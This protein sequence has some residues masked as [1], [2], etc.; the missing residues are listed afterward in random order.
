M[1][2]DGVIGL[3]NTIP[4]HYSADLQR[5]KRL[6]L[7]STVIMGRKTWE[8]LPIQ[9]LPARQNIVITRNRALEVENYPSLDLALEQARHEQVWFI[10]GAELYLEAVQYSELIE[11]TYVPDKISDI[12]SVRFPIIDWSSWEAG[13]KIQFVDDP[14]L[15]H[16]QFK[17]TKARKTT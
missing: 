4:W 3:N 2:A 7:N 15:Y 11:V 8:S 13:S 17:S 9:P 1:T 16:Q 14:R 5:F 6:T 12:S 10:G